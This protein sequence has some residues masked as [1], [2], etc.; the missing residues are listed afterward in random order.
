MS[1]ELKLH[2]DTVKALL[3]LKPKDVMQGFD[4]KGTAFK[5]VKDGEHIIIRIPWE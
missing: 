4:S 5:A 2:E 3:E 1:I